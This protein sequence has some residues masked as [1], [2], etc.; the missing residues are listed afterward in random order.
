MNLSE[1]KILITGGAGGIGNFLANNLVT[2]AKCVI[3]VDN[4]SAS[5]SEIPDND[6]IIKYYCDITNEIKVKET[7]TEI[8][9]KYDGVNVLLNN[10]GIIHSELLINPMKGNE[11]KHSISNWKKV[12]D[13]NLNSIFYV[14]LHVAD[15]LIEAKMDGVIIN[16]SSISAQGNAGQSVYSATKA[17]VESLTKVWSKELSMYNIR[18]ACIAPGFID[19]PSTRQSL[20]GNMINKWKKNI[21]LGRLGNLDE[22]LTSIEFIIQND[23]F[24]GKIL[25]LDGGLTI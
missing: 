12:I 8:F 24:N 9:N 17:A 21:P 13:I 19:T 4:N 5:L 7:I 20:S 25:A 18:T 11:R 10:A 2:K 14:S 15:A 22:M 6:K 3:I 23:Y 1:S 16:T